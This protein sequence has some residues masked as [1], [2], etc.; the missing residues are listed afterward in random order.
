MVHPEPHSLKGTATGFLSIK[1]STYI[2]ISAL[3]T[4][5]LV[6]HFCHYVWDMGVR[7]LLPCWQALVACAKDT[8][9]N[10]PGF[11]IALLAKV[12]TMETASNED[13]LQSPHWCLGTDW[14]LGTGKK[15]LR[16]TFGCWAS[17]DLVLSCAPDT[18]RTEWDCS[19][20]GDF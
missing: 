20:A 11:I 7:E 12:L 16:N 6:L 15:R 5:H 1:L 8:C 19:R 17:E 4:C 3:A 14:P 9:L 13:A 2:S 18:E 10:S